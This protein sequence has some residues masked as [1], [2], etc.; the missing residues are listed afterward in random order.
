VAAEAAASIFTRPGGFGGESPGNCQ[1]GGWAVA[2]IEEGSVRIA[3]LSPLYEAVPPRHY[4]GTERVIS[5]LADELVARGHHVTLFA[6]GG[7]RTRAHLV[8]VV[9]APLRTSMSR[10]EL[11][12]VAPHLHLQMLADAYRGSDDFDIIHAHT[13]IWTLPFVHSTDVPTVITLHGRLDQDVVQRV[14]PLYPDV[15]LVSISDAQRAP[16]DRFPMRWVATVPNGLPLDRYLDEPR[17]EQG[18]DYLAFLGRITPE[19]RPDLAVEIA[20][21]VGLPLRVAAK[22]DPLDE[23]YWREVIQPLFRREGI[24]FIGELGEHDKPAFLAGARAMI[25]PIDWPEPFG[26]VM[27][28]SLAAGTPVVALRRGSVPEILEHGRS[29][30]ICDD[31]DAM[32]AGV[33]AI[34]QL[35]SAACRRRAQAFSPGAMAD[36]YERV[37]DELVARER[38]AGEPARSAVEWGMSA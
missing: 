1:A 6:S 13:D 5:A 19:K 33:E 30:W 25:F 38:W 26:L 23:E 11:S 10:V 7:S 12:D 37:Y 3:L 18:G 14:V 20:K 34:D 29:G 8:P 22:I 35:S 21:R 27:I 9:P 2:P 28:E 31:V 36:R 16:L 17:T 32:V 4:G 24:E 15:P